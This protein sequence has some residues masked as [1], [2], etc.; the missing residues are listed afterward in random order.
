VKNSIW[1]GKICL[2]GTFKPVFEMILHSGAQGYSKVYARRI[3]APL[4]LFSSDF[5]GSNPAVRPKRIA[6]GLDLSFGTQE[7][8]TRKAPFVCGNV[9]S[10]DSLSFGKERNASADISAQCKSEPCLKADTV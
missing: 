8:G 3:L 5:A 1:I 4:S 7:D 6:S 10:Q 9:L 2:Q